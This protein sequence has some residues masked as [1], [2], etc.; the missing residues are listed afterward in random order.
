MDATAPGPVRSHFG[1]QDIDQS[2]TTSDLD[3]RELGLIRLGTNQPLGDYLR[4]VW[5]RRGYMFSVP[6]S[7][8]RSENLDTVLGNVWHVLN[9]LMQVGV[10][11]LVFSVILET[12][13]GL[14]N[15]LT[16]LAVG[17]FTYHFT[18]RS[19]TKGARAIVS[20]DG[21]IR[22]IGFPRVILP[23]ACVLG[24][25]LAYLPAGVV[26]FVVAVATGVDP[27]PCWA[28]LPVVIFVQVL[29][30][31]GLAFITARLT[32][33]FRDFENMLPFILRIVFYMSGILYAIENKIDSPTLRRLFDFNPVYA[34]VSLAR[35]AVFGV[36]APAVL[37]A[38]ACGWA[39][40][41]FVAGFFFFKAGE[42]SYG[43]I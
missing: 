23:I 5:A 2:S 38:S 9:P 31:F 10:Y 14:D 36:A 27:S 35:S 4:S 43:R 25:G 37:W 16:F 12:D 7:D 3:P 39:V 40:V 20:N 21:L 8:F 32:T 6:V 41:L 30:N 11:F 19:T 42:S 22:S 15:F 33:M 1:R 26:M 29:L 17:V 34:V 13:R 28:L 24:E 18:Q